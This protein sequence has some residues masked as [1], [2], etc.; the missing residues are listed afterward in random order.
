MKRIYYL[1]ILLIVINLCTQNMFSQNLN[2]HYYQ[3]LW[4]VNIGIGAGSM[5]RDFS[6]AISFNYYLNNAHLI[7]GRLF[8]VQQRTPL[9]SFGGSFHN[10][11]IHDLGL[12]Y[13][14]L[15]KADFG[16]FSLSAGASYVGGRKY[17]KVAMGF[18]YEDLEER[19]S[20][21]GLPIEIQLFI[22]PSD[23]FGLGFYGFYNFNLER[24]FFGFGF[25]I[26]YGELR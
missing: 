21:F 8:G 23:N 3:D 15:I 25:A 24:N 22:T 11:N 20:T 7:S 18:G 14:R 9:I 19:I 12:L 5:N 10:E 4:W 1:V 2:Q 16:Y 17:T 26:Q 6:Y 13:G